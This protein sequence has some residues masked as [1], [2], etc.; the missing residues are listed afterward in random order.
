MPRRKTPKFEPEVLTPEESAWRTFQHCREELRK[1]AS[2]ELSRDRLRTI[3]ESHPHF[4]DGIGPAHGG[5]TEALVRGVA[6]GDPVQQALLAREVERDRQEILAGAECPLERCLAENV[7]H[8]R[9]S[10]QIA[11]RALKRA[12]REGGEGTVSQV[13]DRCQSSLMR[14]VRQLDEFRCRRRI[15]AANAAKADLRVLKLSGSG[16]PAFVDD[17]DREAETASILPFPSA[18]HAGG[19]AGRRSAGDD[20]APRS[21]ETGSEVSP[22]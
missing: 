9:L 5:L 10:A 16:A 2:D 12:V 20:A 13:H 14:A 3:I 8:C 21:A 6:G 18:I 15:F 11:M 22:A 19:E 7:V 1:G 17:A 4:L